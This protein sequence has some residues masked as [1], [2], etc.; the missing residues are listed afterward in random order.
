MPEIL[1]PYESP[2]LVAEYLL[3]HYGDADAVLGEM[4]GPREAVGF[5]TRLVRELLADVSPTANALDVGCA[6][7]GSSFELAR[8]CRT[9]VGIDFSAA[10]IEA[11]NAL[12][13]S[14]ELA[15]EK[16]VEGAIAESD[17]ARVNE[18]V[19]RG[20]VTFVVGDACSLPPSLGSFDVVLA[21]NLI[22]RL[23]DPGAFL[24]R[25]A[26]LVKPGGQLLL[27][28]PFTWMEEYTPRELWIGARLETGRSFD[29]LQSALAHAFDLEHTV[30]IPFLIREHSRKFQYTVA[31]G[32]R[33]RRR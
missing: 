32:S 29:A 26:E 22:C 28:T 13:R 30:E 9:V 10:F 31:R 4:P 7:G 33:W 21:A 8:R 6:V 16:V 15:F 17:V 5:A 14:G 25:L 3:F 24:D 12:K 20:R 19:E 18:E 2:K 27:T 1:N 23:P 11:A